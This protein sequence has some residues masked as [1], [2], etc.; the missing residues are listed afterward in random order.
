MLLYNYYIIIRFF[1]NLNDELKVNY[2]KKI[3]KINDFSIT[4]FIILKLNI[5]LF[6][7]NHLCFINKYI[8]NIY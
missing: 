5:V 3:I 6:T 2:K 8:I 7:I 1:F 4:F